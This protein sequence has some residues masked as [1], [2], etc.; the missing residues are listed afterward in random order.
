VLMWITVARNHLFVGPFR[1]GHGNGTW[2]TRIDCSRRRRS[3]K[4][5]PFWLVAGLALGESLFS[6]DDHRHHGEDEDEH[7]ERQRTTARILRLFVVSSTRW[8]I[9][10]TNRRM[11]DAV[12]FLLPLPAAPDCPRRSA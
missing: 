1:L 4:P 6:Q 8:E 9:P 7:S 2:L 10:F 12:F 11:S 5:P 3:P